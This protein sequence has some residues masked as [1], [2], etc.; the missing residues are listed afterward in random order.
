MGQL[1]AKLDPL[2]PLLMELLGSW[3]PPEFVLLGAAA[4]GKSTLVDRWAGTIS[5]RAQ[6]PIHISLRAGTKF[7]KFLVKVEKE[8]IGE[9]DY[10]CEVE[11]ADVASLVQEACRVAQ[12]S[13]HA[14]R[15]V[16]HIAGPHLPNLDLLDPGAVD[17][18][19]TSEADSLEHSRHLLYLATVPVPQDPSTSA[20][21]AYVRAHRLQ[22]RTCGVLTCVDQLQVE[23]R[24][25]LEEL[26]RFPVEPAELPHGWVATAK[27]PTNQSDP[28]CEEAEVQVF[29]QL[30]LGSLVEDAQATLP[31]LLDRMSH[32]YCHYVRTEWVRET[33]DRLQ[34][35]T[36]A[37]QKS[38]AALG[39]PV[40][41]CA[42]QALSER[43]HH[44]LRAIAQQTLDALLPAALNASQEKFHSRFVQPLQ[45]VAEQLLCQVPVP[46]DA[47]V[48][49]QLPPVDWAAVEDQVLETCRASANESAAFW[50]QALREALTSPNPFQ[51][52]RF[53]SLLEAL[54]ADVD[55][56]LQ[57]GA[58]A[59]INTASNHLDRY[60]PDISLLLSLAE[61]VTGPASPL[62]KQPFDPRALAHHIADALQQYNGA[63]LARELP[64]H[65]RQTVQ[66]HTD[67]RE[68]CSAERQKLREKMDL[69]VLCQ[70]TL[71]HL[72]GELSIGQT[73]AKGSDSPPPPILVKPWPALA[74]CFKRLASPPRPLSAPP[75][76]QAA[77]DSQSCSGTRMAPLIEQLE[78]ETDPEMVERTLHHLISLSPGL[79]IDTSMA[80]RTVRAIVH[81]MRKPI[82]HA[83]TDRRLTAGILAL[84]RVTSVC[85]LKGA[86]PEAIAAVLDGMAQH[87]GQITVQEA[88]SR[89]LAAWSVHSDWAVQILK[90][91]GAHILL[92]AMGAHPQSI[93]IMAE[94]CFALSNLAL[95]DEEGRIGKAQGTSRILGCLSHHSHQ[96]E[97]QRWALAAV[98]NLS[99]YDE[100][101]A[102]VMACRGVE[103]IVAAMGRA[104]HYAPIQ[105]HGCHALWN[106]ARDDR[107]QV[108]LSTAGA[109]PAVIR[110]MVSH[111]ATLLVQEPGVGALSQLALNV[112]NWV[113][114]A[115]ENG[116]EGVVAAMKCF[117]GHVQLVAHGC[118]ALWQLALNDANKEHIA[119]AEGIQQ[120]VR[121]MAC[122][123]VAPDVQVHG[124]RALWNLALMD[125]NKGRLAEAGG[126]EAVVAAMGAFPNS[127]EVQEAGC[128]ALSHLALEPANHARICEAGSIAVLLR[129]MEHHQGNAEV[130]A[131]GSKALW[132]LAV[133]ATNQQLIRQAG[134]VHTLL[135]AMERHHYHVEVQAKG[136]RALGQ[137][138][139]SPDALPMMAAAHGVRVVTTAMER[140]QSHMELQE[141][142]MALLCLLVR[143]EPNREAL[144][145]TEGVRAVLRVMERQRA[146]A[147]IQEVGCQLLC[148][149]ASDVR[150]SQRVAEAKGIGLVLLAMERHPTHLPVQEWGCRVLAALTGCLGSCPQV[151]SARALRAVV[152]AMEKHPRSLGVQEAGCSALALASLGRVVE[153]KATRAVVAAMQGL[154]AERAI[155]MAG[156]RALLAMLTG[157]DTDQD[158]GRRRV[159]EAEGGTAILQAMAQHQHCLEL[160]ETARRALAC[161]VGTL[162][163]PPA[164]LPMPRSPPIVVQA[165]PL[166]MPL[167]LGAGLMPLPLPLHSMSTTGSPFMQTMSPP[168]HSGAIAPMSLPPPSGPMVGLQPLMSF[169]AGIPLPYGHGR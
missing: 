19:A 132:H 23:D 13:G 125:C 24:A 85:L 5:V 57:A 166:P 130:Q 31:T 21:M 51:L 67:W 54:M 15:I 59:L 26:L 156:V 91:D 82:A 18:T 121:A 17:A 93:S 139:R 88:G 135:L 113:P 90:A 95:E 112:A 143:H 50:R 158:R 157:P 100:Q 65:W 44:Q 81:Q 74:K 30:G 42:G 20:A 22:L 140:Y 106:L 96:E 97:L 165:P 68:S 75:V 39:L 163:T 144:L 168:L 35:E 14:A 155:Q 58:K 133:S 160:Q 63:A 115:Q 87:L 150:G 43:E 86:D 111:P 152:R 136:C 129:T 41:S 164:P 137:L 149:V 64:T 52:G 122:H 16:V 33:L 66:R 104:G 11:D 148:S 114:I 1:F 151:A 7:L 92:E 29:R 159:M 145:Q 12:G 77:G 55:A 9:L 167:R 61:V 48:A 103:A 38:N 116:I 131:K 2:R 69:I 119:E 153:A 141:A 8:I 83:G 102:V 117:M 72:G 110:A 70:D 162:P 123:P 60:S 36:T 161:L 134:G 45:S 105:G 6:V 108:A 56:I 118:Q 89:T 169:H 27:P 107:C 53:N 25:W 109:I 34:Q 147:T 78:T 10:S 138:A 127:V 76:H 46:Y 37:T 49:A 40:G 124:L 94:S 146:D 84:G 120:I 73:K 71:S 28:C 128:G 142:G 126:V 79:T 47:A 154:P 32:L 98:A 4:S 3:H 101:K 99:A 62:C 80:H